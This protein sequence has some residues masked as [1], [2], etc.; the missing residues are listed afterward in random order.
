[1]KFTCMILNWLRIFG[2]RFVRI[3]LALT[4]VIVLI[5]AKGSET[6]QIKLNKEFRNFD[7]VVS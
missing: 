7:V 5:V 4:L 3:I 2:L 6:G 1:M